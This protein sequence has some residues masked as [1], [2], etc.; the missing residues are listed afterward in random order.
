MAGDQKY[1]VPRPYNNT[2]APTAVVPRPYNN[3]T[4]PTA[5]S[6]R[7]RV[8]PPSQLDRNDLK[9]ISLRSRA[10]LLSVFLEKPCFKSRPFVIYGLGIIHVNIP[11]TNGDNRVFNRVIVF[12]ITMKNYN[13]GKIRCFEKMFR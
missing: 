1:L 5:V 7:G 13:T 11:L 8:P 2:T 6:S 9:R 4:V 12:L 3:T 10:F